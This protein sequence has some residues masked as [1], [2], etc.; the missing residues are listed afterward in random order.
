MA[1][2][3][4]GLAL[5]MA[6]GSVPIAEKE[7]TTKPIIKTETSTRSE[8]ETIVS[9]SSPHSN[10]GILLIDMQD[11]FLQEISEAEKAREIPRIIKVLN[12]AGNRRIPIVILEYDGNGQTIDVLR[13]EIISLRTDVRYIVK[14]SDDGFYQTSL[15]DHLKQLQV[16]DLILM[17]INATGCV[18]TT[19]AGALNHGF[20]IITSRDVIAQPPSWVDDQKDEG[21]EGARWYQREGQLVNNYHELLKICERNAP[22]RKPFYSIFWD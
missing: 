14:S 10:L 19:G 16:K 13:R 3:L 8:I 1:N 12:Y 9:V 22:K 4:S 21:I 11:D 5:A 7:E 6:L 2:F 18:K 17:G 20:S 15:A